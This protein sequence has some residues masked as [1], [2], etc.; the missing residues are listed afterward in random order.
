METL[1]EPMLVEG[2]RVLLGPVKNGRISGG[3]VDRPSAR[4]RVEPPPQPATVHP[5]PLGIGG[6]AP[7]TTR[8]TP[9]PRSPEVCPTVVG[10]ENRGASMDPSRWSGGLLE[11]GFPCLRK[12]RRTE[13]TERGASR[14]PTLNI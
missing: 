12:P 3:I 6:A 9:G 14:V 10:V 7:S 13:P 8:F 1:R 2:D 5:N 4:P 11:L